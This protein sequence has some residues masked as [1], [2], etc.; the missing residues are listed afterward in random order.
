MK[1][2][3]TLVS[4][5]VGMFSCN[6][7]SQDFSKRTVTGKQAATEEIRKA[8]V[9][10]NTKSFYD[11]LIKDKETAISIIEPILFRVYG[12]DNIVKERPYECYMIN[13]YWYIS[14][15]LPKDLNSNS[16]VFEIIISSKD[17]QVIK[18]IHGK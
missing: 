16:G 2:I 1:I 6:S 10:K 17:T 11:T 3:L 13:D 14:G 8:L 15:T 12:R 4:L 9:N 18:L 5:I 7:F